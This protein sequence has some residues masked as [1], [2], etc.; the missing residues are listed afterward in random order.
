[1]GG[2]KSVPLS[3]TGVTSVEWLTF[4][5]DEELVKVSIHSQYTVTT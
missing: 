2:G 4:K 3:S 1:M 5:S